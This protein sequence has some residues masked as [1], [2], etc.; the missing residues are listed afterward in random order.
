MIRDRIKLSAKSVIKLMLL[1]G[2][3]IFILAGSLTA[4]ITLQRSLRYELKEGYPVG[5][6]WADFDGNGW[7]DLAIACGLDS[8][9]GHNKIFFNIGG[10]L[11]TDSVWISE[12]VQ[13]AGN[14]YIADLD[15]NNEPDLIVN[16]LGLL[17]TGFQDEYHVFYLNDGGLP[18][19]PSWYSK[20]SVGFSCTTGDPDGDGDLDI[21]F[22]EGIAAVSKYLTAK[23][24][25]N[26]NGTF[27]TLPFWET[28]ATHNYNDAAFV[29]LDRDGDLDLVMVAKTMPLSAYYNNNGVLETAPSYSSPFLGGRQLAVGDID[30]DGYYDVAV[31]ICGFSPMT[32]GYFCVYKNNNGTLEDYPSWSCEYYN[33]PA[34]VEFADM[35]ADGD[36]DL[37]AGGWYSPFGIFEN[38]DGNLPDRFT[39]VNAGERF[40]QQAAVADFDNDGLVDT[41]KVFTTDGNLKLFYLDHNNIQRINSVIFNGVPVYINNYCYDLKDGWLSFSS[42]PE[43]GGTLTVNYTY[44]N[45]LDMA[46]TATEAVFVFENKGSDF[47]RPPEDINLLVLVDDDFGANYCM[48]NSLNILEHFEAYGWDITLASVNENLSPCDYAALIGCRS[49]T[50]DTLISQIDDVTQFDIISIMPGDGYSNLYNN[51]D[52]NALLQNANEAGIVISAWCK[53]VRLLAAADIIE[54]RRVTGKSTYA[55]EYIAAGADYLGAGILPVVDGNIVTST[56]SNYYRTEIC[57]TIVKALPPVITNTTRFPEAPTSKDS[58]IVTA[59]I[60]DNYN[61]I[62]LAVIYADVSGDFAPF[63]MYDDGNHHD[64]AVGDS[65]FGGIIPP[66]KSGEVLYYIYAEDDVTAPASDPSDAPVTTYSYISSGCC[67]GVT[68]NVDCT[69]EEIPDISDITRLIDYLYISHAEL[70]CPEEADVNDSGGEPDISDITYLIDH[71]YISHK[72]LPEC[73]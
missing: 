13:P 16:S 26:D 72:D 32:D 45:D 65:V 54:G 17:S 33:E 8:Y 15:K 24:Y 49:I 59:R 5:L 39:W 10:E 20:P 51:P 52:V 57:E 29:D 38:I 31:A 47:R 60:T 27:D 23:M 55:N 58:V 61:D 41:Q 22:T 46:V 36:L 66:G 71:L 14:L 70:C 9:C 3:I 44:S 73:P 62:G 40:P 67:F 18:Q 43:N 34:Y 56:R 28:D 68:G 63:V 11:S 48:N 37:I 35:D 4:E 25:V 42:A 64:G 69:E 19:T 6:G 50:V 12:N 7:P 1:L 30:K 21:L 53:G 2:L